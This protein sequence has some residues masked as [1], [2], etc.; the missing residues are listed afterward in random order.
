VK[1]VATRAIGY[2]MPG[3]VV[4]GNSIADVTEAIDEAVARARAGLGPTLVECKTYRTKGHSRSDRNRY[5]SKD[6]IEDWKRRDPIPAFVG[7]LVAHGILSEKEAAAVDAATTQ[8]IADAIVFAQNGTDPTGIDIA[9]EV[10][11]PYVAGASA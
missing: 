2:N 4:D 9:S 8:E 11:T 1:D 7:E 3:V 10:Y 6:E 5:R